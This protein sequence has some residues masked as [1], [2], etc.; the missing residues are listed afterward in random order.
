MMDAAIG[1]VGAGGWG[2]ALA[3]LLASRGRCVTLWARD[4]AKVRRL[5]CSRVNE[6]YLP[7]IA[8]PASVEFTSDLEAVARHRYLILAVPAQGV[9]G[10]WQRLAPLIRPGHLVLNT[11]KGIEL[12]T[13]KR[14]SELLL[15][16]GALRREQLAVLSGPN[17]AEEVARGLPTAT[18][19]AAHAS[20]TALAWQELLMTPVFRV[21][22]SDDVTG[23]ELG[24]ALK[25]VIALACGIADGLGYGDN[26]KA[27]IIT[28][29]LAETARLGIALGAHPITF[30]GLSGVGDLIATCY[31][32]HS[33]NTRAGRLIGKGV[34]IN[35]VIG[36]T[37]MV[38]EGI[39]TCRAAL[40]LAQRMGVEM[41]ITQAV[42]DVLFGGK[43]PSELVS[44]LMGR[45]PKAEH[46]DLFSKLSATGDPL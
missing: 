22:T 10:L 39:P 1:I 5:S 38:I 46:L 21:Y 2:S 45:D 44:G 8:F 24:G 6:P 30:S 37:P 35:E 23:V 11:A 19:V 12:T 3:I 9:R 16:N 43:N 32:S 13:G 28:R 20:E 27:A 15:E 25:N 40:V 17:H 31:S 42:S 26:T 36:S 29:G 14:L 4:E 33:R 41:P 34:S 18:V 7:G